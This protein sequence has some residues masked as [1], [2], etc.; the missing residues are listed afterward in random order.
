MHKD[1]VKTKVGIILMILAF[2]TV[3]IVFLMN[4]PISQDLNYHEFSDTN[5]F[6]SLPNA[7]N[8][9]SNIPFIIAGSV[10]LLSLLGVSKYSIQ[11][12]DANKLS[13]F[14][15][16][17]GLILVGFGSG[18]YHLNP[19]NETL[20]WDRIPMTIAFMGLYAIII[21]EYISEKL[22]KFL[23]IPLLLAGVCSVMYWWF[24]EMNGAGDL[25]FYAMV[26]FFPILTIPI[27]LLCFNGKYSHARGYW[28]LI[29][30]YVGA[31][32]F[33]TFDYQIH[34]FIGGISGHSIKHVLPA[35]G[36]YY[37]ITAYRKRISY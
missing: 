37:L 13:Y 29:M 7:L 33:E 10:G 32:V 22:G 19:N 16:F 30:A 25:R 12:L 8:V 3:V 6:I 5:T 18:Y 17:T 15:L 11:V 20:V 1:S 2:V 21:S 26:Q 36:V 14:A 23:L 34:Q 9:I 27:I 31:K 28:V 4:D 35:L 24:S